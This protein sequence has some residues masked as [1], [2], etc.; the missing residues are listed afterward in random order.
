MDTATKTWSISEVSKMFHLAP[1]TLRYYERLGL[2][3]NVHQEHN[4]RMYTKEHLEKLNSITCFKNSG[5]TMK[6]LQVLLQYQETGPDLNNILS[7]LKDHQ[8]KIE[9]QL[10]PV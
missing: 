8:V 7:L 10:G 2:L 4:H 6:E 1:S 3:K 5:M 9:D